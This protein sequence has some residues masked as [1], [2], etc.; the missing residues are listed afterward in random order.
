MSKRFT[1]TVGRPSLSTLIGREIEGGRVSRVDGIH[2]PT[3][4]DMSTALLGVLDP[5]STTVMNEPEARWHYSEMHVRFPE[6]LTVWRA[7]PDKKPADLGWDAHA[8][9]R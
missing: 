7:S 8:Y 6:A 9:S 4:Q 3:G 2:F 1:V 5:T